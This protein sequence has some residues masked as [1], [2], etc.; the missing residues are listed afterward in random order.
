MVFS[1]KTFDEERALYG[2]DG[3]KVV[4]CRFDGPADG[5]SALKECKHLEIEG[6]YFNL[7]YPFWH[8]TDAVI[9]DCEM[10]EKCRAALWYDD[11]V[12][13]ENCRMLGIK[14]LREC[15]NVKLTDSSV[16]SPEFLWRCKGVQVENTNIESEYPFFEC[17]DLDITGLTMTGKYSFQ[18]VENAVIRN[19]ELNTKDAFWHSKNVT[20]YDSV[21]RGEYL[22][23]YSENL[24]LVRCKIIGTQPLCY[25]KGLILEACTMEG[26]DLTFERSEVQATILGH[27]DSIKNPASG[28]I[29]AGS[30]GEQILEPEY[31]DMGRV[32]ILCR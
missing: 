5:E 26:T 6:S 2:L 21:V 7:R 23:W 29:I 22:G 20:V 31:M 30:I 32:E 19:S 14:A 4:N 17:T 15:R 25:C 28:K 12:S 8:V 10:T 27:I 13:L 11:T 1:E 16:V 3:A 9:R 24:K 18:Y